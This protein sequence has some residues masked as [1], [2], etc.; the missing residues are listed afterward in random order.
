MVEKGVLY[1]CPTPIGNLDDITLRTLK[2][3][4]GVDLIAAEDTR[5][6][7]Q[8]LNHFEIKK[9]LTSYHEHNTREKGPSLVDKLKKGTSIGLVSDAG[10]PGISDPGEGLIKLCIEEGIRVE[11][12]PGATASIVAL[13]ASGLDTRKFV[14]EGF[15][16]SSKREKRQRL[17]ELESERRT[18]IIYESPYRVKETLE[19][20]EEVLGSRKISV[21]RELTKR[22]EETI[23]GE[24]KEVREL[25]TEDKIRGEFVLVV[26]GSKEEIIEEVI[27]IKKELQKCMEAGM[28]KSQSVKFVAKT[29]GL[30][31]NEVYQESLDL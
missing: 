16:A 26:E 10:M 6:S 21:S 3:L 5:R 20:M 18:M 15:L 8:L 7:L 24:I 17:E 12:L 22:Y 23:R 13:V 1:I 11:V 4:E 19:L 31:K 2:V 29:L 30:A 28:S 27:D 9:P 14:F 25:L